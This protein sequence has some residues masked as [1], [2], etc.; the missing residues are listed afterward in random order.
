MQSSVDNH[1]GGSYIVKAQ[2]M[3]V[4]NVS[5]HTSISSLDSVVHG[6]LRNHFNELLNNKVYDIFKELFGSINIVSMKE[7]LPKVNIYNDTIARFVEEINSKYGMTLPFTHLE[8]HEVGQ[9]AE[10]FQVA[11]GNKEGF[12]PPRPWKVHEEPHRAE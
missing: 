3:Q 9:W 4:E 7:T 6:Y 1:L 10:T 12:E 8:P 11:S 2:V 5:C